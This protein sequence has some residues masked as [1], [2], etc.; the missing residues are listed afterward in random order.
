MAFSGPY[1]I[2]I[3][4]KT[5][6]I[7]EYGLDAMYLLEGTER[8]LLIDTGSGLLDLDPI[9]RTLTDKPYDV[10]L[11]HSHLDHCGGISQFK[12]VYIHPLDEEAAKEDSYESRRNYAEMLGNMGAFEAYGY[13]LDDVKKCGELP[14]FHHVE[15]GYIFE[16]GDR[17]VEV[18]HV[19]GHTPGGISLMDDKNRILFSGDCCNVNTLI[20]GSSVTTLLRAVRK[21]IAIKDRFDQNYNG[22]VGYAGMRAVFSQPESVPYD[23]EHLCIDVL[24]GTAKPEKV[25]FL[26]R[27]TLKLSYN[28]AGISYNPDRLIDPGEEPEEY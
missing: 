20:M 9:V 3:A 17:P 1:I 4:P 21:V 15:E 6:C 11:T 27:E 12:E 5:Y 25:N 19:P 16:L 14:V 2:E 26:G 7:N 13:T 18:I 23:L 8:A 24:K 10:V 28:H 22:H